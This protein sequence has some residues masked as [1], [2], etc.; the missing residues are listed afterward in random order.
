MSRPAQKRKA[1]A[2]SD[3]EAAGAGPAAGPLGPACPGRPARKRSL[4]ELQGAADGLRSGA[5]KGALAGE[6]SWSPQHP[7]M[8]LVVSC[9]TACCLQRP[10]L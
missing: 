3:P 1:S 10:V 4:A 2:I 6:L 9:R 5:G 8:L 7:R